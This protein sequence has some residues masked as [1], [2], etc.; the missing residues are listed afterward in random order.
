[1]NVL[2]VVSGGIAA[3]KSCQLARDLGRAGHRVRAVL[4]PG[5]TR[6]VTAQSFEAL[7][8]EPAYVE[9]WRPR[10]G[11]MEHI[12]LARWADLVVCAPATADLLARMTQGMANDL[13]TT[14]LLAYDGPVLVAPAMNPTM[15]S[16]PATQENLARL[17]ER[18]VLVIGP[19]SGD[20]ACGEEGPGRMVEPAEI[21]ARVEELV[22]AGD[23]PLTGRHVLLTAGP[24]REHLDPA[25]YL[26]N[27][28]TG[29]M[30]LE[31]ARAARR[32]GARVTLV[33][34]PMTAPAEPGVE[35]VRVTSAA[36]MYE[37]VMARVG[38][39]DVFV[40]A[41]AVADWTPR[42][43]S[44]EKEAKAGETRAIEMVRT[45]DILAEVA[46]GRRPGQVLVGFAAETSDVVARGEAK[47]ARKG[48][49]L[50]VANRIGAPGTGFGSRGNQAAILEEGAPAP[51]GLEELSKAALAEALVARIVARL[52]GA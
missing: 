16:H 28:S 5:A 10:E 40:G 26:S 14:T 17:R 3:Y 13:A 33:R 47:R 41:A 7:T 46:A 39:A 24:T 48:V 22:G 49:D 19:A 35:E 38:E 15:F 12:D 6:F 52:L 42:E 27:P 8:G 18:G 29:T 23:G 21:A 2:L 51:A 32:A 20:T 36:E 4:T 11:P 34:G 9:L 31:I 25:R 30:G 50:L 44:A 45:R 1:M 43:V 37:A